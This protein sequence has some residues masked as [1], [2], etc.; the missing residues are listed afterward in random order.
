[1]LVLSRKMN[2]EIVI[3]DNI[4]ITIVEIGPGRVKIG[5]QAP[6]SVA[7]DR[8]EISEQKKAAELA[9]TPV[10][11]VQKPVVFNRIADVLPPVPNPM[12][13]IIPPA[14]TPDNTHTNR[15][16]AIRKR[17]PKKPR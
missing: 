1:M 11:P 7:V 13:A 12:S 5:I 14:V 4:R 17:L 8:G 3:G 9:A 10:V 6:R 15:L 16:D 2:E